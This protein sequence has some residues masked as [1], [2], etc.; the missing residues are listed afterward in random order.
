GSLI[1]PKQYKEFSFPYMKELVEAVKEAGGAPPTLHIC[2]N[3][4]KIWQAMADTGAAVLSIEDKI[5]L[6]EIK[7][8]VGDR[9]M[10]AGNIR[11]T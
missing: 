7:H 3:T 4:K 5:D 6:S 2:G 11:P 1:G 10:I 9:V 8:A